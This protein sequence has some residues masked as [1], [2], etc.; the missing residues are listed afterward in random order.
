MNHYPSLES[1]LG[2]GLPHRP[3]FL[4]VSAQWDCR[5]DRLFWKRLRQALRALRALPTHLAARCH[6]TMGR[7]AEFRWRCGLFRFG[8][9]LLG[10]AWCRNQWHV[11]EMPETLPSG[12]AVLCPFAR[13]CCTSCSDSTAG[14]VTALLRHNRELCPSKTGFFVT[15]VWFRSSCSGSNH[16]CPSNKDCTCSIGVVVTQF[17]ANILVCTLKSLT[18][19]VKLPDHDRVATLLAKV[20]ALVAT[21]LPRL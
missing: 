8:L 18:C 11:Q 10:W 5:P 3:V 15:F 7:L 21:V 4:P 6:Q 12:V 19:P 20:A 14:K 2:S 9:G 17:R 13:G 16:Y 1:R